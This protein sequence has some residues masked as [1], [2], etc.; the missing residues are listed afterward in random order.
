[1]QAIFFVPF[2]ASEKSYSPCLRPPP[3]LR[4]LTQRLESVVTRSTLPPN[5]T[6]SG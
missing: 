4:G 5:L 2:E 1:M 6:H 3:C